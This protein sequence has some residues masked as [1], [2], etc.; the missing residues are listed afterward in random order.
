MNL[1][2]GSRFLIPIPDCMRSMLTLKSLTNCL[3]TGLVILLKMVAKSSFITKEYSL[4]QTTCRYLTSPVSDAIELFF[5]G[6]SSRSWEM[7]RRC[8]VL[9]V[10]PVTWGG[11]NIINASK[12]LKKNALAKY[13]MDSL[14]DIKN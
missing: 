8:L 5:S 11:K 10:L 1:D 14:K 3:L 12:T 7:V 13:G 9:T 6:T 2:N 4:E